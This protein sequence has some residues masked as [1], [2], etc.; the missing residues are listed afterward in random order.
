MAFPNAS[1]HYNRFGGSIGGPIISKKILGGK[2][3][4]FANYE[5]FRWPYAQ[6]ITRSVPS[7]AMR[8]GLLTFGG[9][10]YNLNPTPVTYNGVT[11]MPAQCPAGP[12]DPRGIGINPLVQQMWNQYMPLSNTPNCSRCDGTNILGFT[13]NMSTP[14]SSNFGVARLDHDFGDKWHF[15]SSY[16][17]YNLQNFNTNQVDIGGFFPGDVKGVPTSLSSLPQ[18]PWFFVAG[19]SANI[20][21]NFSNDIHYSYLRNWWAY[22]RTGGP[23]QFP[24]LGGALEPGGESQ[25]G[26]LLPYNVNTQNTRTRFWD[27][28]DNMIR[29]DATWLKGKHMIQFGGMYQHNFNWHQRTD[30]GGG[31]NYYPTYQLG[32][33]GG[34]GIDMTGYIPAGFSGSKTTYGRDYAEVLGIVSAS[35]VA[36]TR[37]G[38]NLTLNP[39]L[40]PAEDRVTIPYYNFYGSDTWRMTPR[41]T[42]TYGLGWTLEMPPTEA[43]G[44][45]VIFVG[46]DNTPISTTA[47]LNT[48][49]AMALQ[50][51]VYNPRGGLQPHRQRSQPPFVYLQSVLRGVEPACRRV[52]GCLR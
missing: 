28:Q 34:A 21:N 1:Y 50:G 37:T 39:P 12:C 2:T 19:L 36:Y 40:T 46:P 38:N 7:A 35:Q 14:Q 31:I 15:M 8:L 44:K 22:E 26:S 3:Y 51:Q 33:N 30:N 27:G 13:A 25:T 32:T 23:V 6:N 4:F 45:Q 11:Y 52:L 16:R 29:D 20:T 5:G 10:T 24:G 41:F 49:K 42:L 18:Q 9:T 48:T 47:Y 43:T 17:Y